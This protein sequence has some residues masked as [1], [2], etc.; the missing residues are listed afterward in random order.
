MKYRLI[1]ICL[2][3]SLHW[4]AWGQSS[5]ADQSDCIYL[6]TDYGA[7]GDG[8]SDNQ[9][10]IQQ[11]IDECSDKGGGQVC[12]PSGHFVASEIV[13]KNNVQ[14]KFDRNSRLE[15]AIV[16]DGV[17]NVGI[18]GHPEDRLTMIGP[19][20][21]LN[22]EQL[23]LKH[24]FSRN[25]WVFRDCRTVTVDN[26]HIEQEMR[27]QANG[28]A[29][30]F[31]D[32]HDVFVS[33][34]EITCND[35]AFCLKRSGENI[36]ITS[37]LICGRQAASFKIG[38][39]TD[40]AFRNISMTNCV[41]FNSNRAG[42]NIEAVDG[43]D[44][45]G[46]R[47]SGIQMCNVAAPFYIRLGNRDRYAKGI[48]SIRNID[49]SDIH[50]V[51]M[52]HDEGIGSS[53]MGLPNH[54]VENV[55]IR[56]VHITTQGGWTKAQAARKVPARANFYP[57]YDI[58]GVMPAYGFFC[59]YVRGLSLSDITLSYAQPDLR[60]AVQ[61]EHV[62]D[63]E[64]EALRAQH[65]IPRNQYV[66][67][68][69]A[70]EPT[71]VLEEVR[72][73]F[74]HRNIA[75]ALSPLAEIRGAGSADITLVDN[76][77][78]FSQVPPYRIAPEVTGWLTLTPM[79]EAR[80]ASLEIPE[81]KAGS[82]ATASV[83]VIN[84][85]PAGHFPVELRTGGEVLDRQWTWLAAGEEKI[86]ALN[87]PPLYGMKDYELQSGAVSRQVRPL[88]V[89]AAL[90]YEEM[91]AP[92]TVG[93]KEPVSVHVT[94]R[95]AGSEPLKE[96]V[97]LRQGEK[98]VASQALTLAPGEEKVAAMQAVFPRAGRYELS[99]GELKKSV[100]VNPLWIDAN[101]NGQL[102]AKEAS[103]A[104][105]P[106]AL[107]AAKAGDLI[108]VNPGHFLIDSSAL[109]LRID[110]L[111]LTIRSAAGYEQTIV[112]AVD[113]N[114]ERQE[115]HALFYV[116]ADGVTIEGLTLSTGVYNVHVEKAKETVIRNNFFNVSRRYHIHM[117]DAAGVEIAENRSRVGRYNFLT[118]TNSSGCV[119]RDNYHYEDPCGYMAINSHNNSFLR[120]HFDSLSWYG[121]TLQNS[122]NNLV[123]DNLFEAGRILGL[124]CRNG[125]AGNRIVKNT[126]LGNRTEAVLMTGHCT[127]NII[128]QNNILGNRG[129]A[130]TNESDGPVDA[131]GNWWGA[132]DG[133]GGQGPGSGD[134]V[135][136]N[137]RFESWLKEA[138]RNS[139][140]ERLEGH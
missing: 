118:M 49:I 27:R 131:A 91:E 43:S 88:P 99:A 73:A 82:P 22:A 72:N 94:V 71:I 128:T 24:I 136:E 105:F 65:W 57:E 53:I 138:V 113:A 108:L 107:Q 19:V 74:I 16:I 134:T 48:G 44:I 116:A 103:F 45:D 20:R 9:A 37:S 126:F 102:D 70:S 104:G 50:F 12:F 34:S 1:A 90:V 86:V 60:P 124:Q 111:G 10:A 114:E 84:P 28:V 92:T 120:N 112:Q 62:E 14:L 41:L 36:H 109:P 135:D 55:T 96:T 76:R 59:R 40:G 61:C 98:T 101:G 15:S 42:I 52:Q 133:P 5:P 3:C 26:V 30:T 121:I 127:D 87:V 140:T 58:Y 7:K 115:Q 75:P 39:E 6:I 97:F 8:I 54:P 25:G 35:D 18:I 93:V 129:L 139:W 32:S 31:V 33:N 137:V 21:L 23:T 106:E 29:I 122:N 83:S 89:P 11:A 125:C 56:N 78:D 51:G 80:V 17:R 46:V 69:E 64:I 100:S 79:A 110:Q 63:L 81:L 2:L 38:T 130:V 47:I 85:G 66:E 123:E 95:N 68:F 117:V 77:L 132:P 119:I 4:I 67:P 13:L